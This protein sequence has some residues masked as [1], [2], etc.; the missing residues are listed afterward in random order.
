MPTPNRYLR[1][2][3]LAFAVCAISSAWMFF[4][5]S[6]D[7]VA[8]GITYRTLSA[9]P[10]LLAI[11]TLM[12][13][14]PPGRGIGKRAGPLPGL[15]AVGVP[16]VQQKG[17]SKKALPADGAVAPDAL[18]AGLTVPLGEGGTLLSGH[19]YVIVYF[20]TSPGCSKVIHRV[21]KL[22]RLMRSCAEWLHVLMVSHEALPR[23][24]SYAQIWHG[25]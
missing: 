2:G 18:A 5:R 8:E 3:F 19:A 21:E 25:K 7:E 15:T 17:A 14:P 4:I 10:C 6:H 9:F 16:K 22:N 13:Y 24:E 23:L 1:P 12:Q 20:N 11:W